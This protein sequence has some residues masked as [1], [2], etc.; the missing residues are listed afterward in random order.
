MIRNFFY[1]EM[2]CFDGELINFIGCWIRNIFLVVVLGAIAIGVLIGKSVS[3]S[4][5]ALDWDLAVSAF[6]NW[7][8]SKAAVPCNCCGQPLVVF[9]QQLSFVIR[10]PN[11]HERVLPKDHPRNLKYRL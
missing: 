9:E 4:S 2:L 3:S 11:G 6:E 7:R 8:D 10:C 1:E 5:V